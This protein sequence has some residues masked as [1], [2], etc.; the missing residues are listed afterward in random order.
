MYDVPDHGEI[1]KCIITEET[2]REG[3]LPLLLTKTQV[4]EAST[5]QLREAARGARPDRVRQGWRRGAETMRDRG[6]R[7]WMAADEDTQPEKNAP[8]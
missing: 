7:V 8:S 4:D 6:H 5:R 1:R 2:I 3:R